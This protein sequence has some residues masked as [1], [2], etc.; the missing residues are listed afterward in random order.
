MLANLTIH[1][2]KISNRKP[3]FGLLFGA[4]ALAYWYPPAEFFN[5]ENLA[6]R[7]IAVIAIIF[8]PIFFANKGF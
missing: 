5:I 6:L 7:Y 2:F 1:H 4:L 8:S 3:L